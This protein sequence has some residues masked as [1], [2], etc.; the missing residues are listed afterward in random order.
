MRTI[1][2]EMALFL[3]KGEINGRA[4]FNIVYRPTLRSDLLNIRLVV[5]KAPL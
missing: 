5:L 2:E 1:P 3:D 4:S